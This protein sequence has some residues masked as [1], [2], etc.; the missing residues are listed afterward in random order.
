MEIKL[1]VDKHYQNFSKILS[2]NLT[3]GLTGSFG[4]GKSTVLDIF[5][6]IGFDTYS[7]DKE[8]HNLY[9]RK[10]IQEKLK[11]KIPEAFVAKTKNKKNLDKQKLRK[12]VFSNKKKLSFLESIIHPVIKKQCV[13]LINSSEK[14]LICEIPILVKSGLEKHFKKIITVE[15][16]QEKRLHRTLKRYKN[17]LTKEEFFAIE[18]SQSTEKERSLMS[19]AVI[20]NNGSLE[21]LE[22]KILEV[23]SVFCSKENNF[24]PGTKGEL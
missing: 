13:S 6:R 15:A 18:K 23:I 1:R 5:E 7:A 4:S 24:Q 9:S 14:N 8:V 11:T 20:E 19:D 12:I 2:K 16:K 17:E 21:D 10:E 3:I 22:K